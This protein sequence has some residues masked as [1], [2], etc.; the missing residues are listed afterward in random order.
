MSETSTCVGPQ[1][2]RDVLIKARS[3]CASHYQ[4]LKRGR[5]LTALRPIRKHNMSAEEMGKWISEQVEIDPDSGCWIWPFALRKGY[6]AVEFQGKTWLVHRLT[7][8][9]FVGPLAD[10]LVVDHIDCISTA[11]CNP[12][13]LR[14]V[15]QA[16]NQQNRRSPSTANTSG[17]VG[18][19]WA[20]RHEKWHVQIMV[21]RKHHH[22]GYFTNLDDA[23]AA[24]KAAEQKYHP[25]RDPEYREPDAD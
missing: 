19:Y 9:I 2:D 13:H 11:C 7:F 6:G 14:Q 10:G 5:P 3:L 21:D 17:H 23:I 15:R 12:G 18:I 8:S 24:R 16:G 20:K 25:Y 1:C 22:L 4:Q